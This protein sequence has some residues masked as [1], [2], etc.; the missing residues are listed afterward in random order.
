M[1]GVARGIRGRVGD[2]LPS[3]GSG[4]LRERRPDS[5]RRPIGV[6]GMRAY[7]PMLVVACAALGGGASAAPS[8][9]A[10]SPAEVARPDATLRLSEGRLSTGLAYMWGR[11]RLSFQD[12]RHEFRISGA[13]VADVQALNLSATG[14]VYHLARL[15]DFSGRYV[16]VDGVNVPAAERDTVPMRNEHGV[17]IMLRVAAAGP[18]PARAAGGV[19]IQLSD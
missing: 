17:V 3:A 5:G 19:H 1:T 14:N 6:R 16:A 7:V 12:R 11:G 2:S 8:A 4:A 10:V 15:A 18:Q 9:D 13:P